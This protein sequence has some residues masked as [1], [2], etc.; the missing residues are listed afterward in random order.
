[1]NEQLLL[2]GLGIVSGCWA[3][4]VVGFTTRLRVARASHAAAAALSASYADNAIRDLDA[5]NA[6]IASLRDTLA[7]T[8][9]LLTDAQGTIGVLEQH[10]AD[11]DLQ[12]DVALATCRSSHARI[13]ELELHALDVE[14]QLAV[15]QQEITNLEARL[16][17]PEPSPA[18]LVLLDAAARPERLQDGPVAVPDGCRVETVRYHAQTRV[19]G[20][21]GKFVRLTGQVEPSNDFV[22]GRDRKDGWA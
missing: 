6:V 15:A 19:R 10:L 14:T 11:A 13:G 9:R 18:D 7:D 17:L 4:T 1:M 2:G 3:L 5:A 20:P 21:G 12:R 22:V 8:S 16:R